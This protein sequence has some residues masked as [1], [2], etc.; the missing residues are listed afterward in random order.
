MGTGGNSDNMSKVEVRSVRTV[1]VGGCLS[2]VGS[3]LVSKGCGPSPMGQIVVPGPNKDR[4][5]LKVPAIG[6]EVI[7]VTVGVTVRPMFRTS[8][9]SY[10]CKFQPGEDTGR[11]L[12]IM[13]G[14]YGGGNC[15][16]MSTSV[17]GFFSGM[18]RSGLVGLMRREVSSHEV[19]GLVER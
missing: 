3:R 5:L 13:E 7:R 1:K 12:R 10:S 2:R 8:F 17:R 15:C 6:S 11:T 4:E 19:L 9:E 16:M 14:T 18:G